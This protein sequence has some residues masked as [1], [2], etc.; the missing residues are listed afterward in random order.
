FDP[1]RMRV[2]LGLKQLGDDPWLGV[3]RRYP[4]GTRMF[5]KVTNIADYGAFVELEPGIEGLV[6]VSEM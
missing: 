3:A 6:H 1:E 5:G 4:Q 2:S